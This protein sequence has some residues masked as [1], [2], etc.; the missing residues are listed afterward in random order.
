[1]VAPPFRGG[2]IYDYL[3]LKGLQWAFTQQYVYV[4]GSV[5][6]GRRMVDRLQQLHFKKASQVVENA[7]PYGER[8][9][10]QPLICNLI[11]EIESINEHLRRLA[12]A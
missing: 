11:I 2:V 3:I 4:N 12:W 5:R 6:P 1:M 7:S 10:V 8:H 9:L